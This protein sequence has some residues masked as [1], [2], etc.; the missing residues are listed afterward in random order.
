MNQQTAGFR[1]DRAT[2][3]AYI[4]LTL[5][6]LQISFIGPIMPFLRAEMGLSYMEG[7]LH[8]SAFAL[9]MMATGFLCA[10]LE[11]LIGRKGAMIVAALGLTIGF[12][13]LVVARTPIL[14]ILAAGGMGLIGS[15]IVVY[16]PLVLLGIHGQEGGRAIS[17]SNLMS[18]LGA[19]IA[20]MAVWLFTDTIGWRAVGMVGWVIMLVSM[21]AIRGAH[22]PSN[23]EEVAHTGS[24]LG[25]TYWTYWF[26]LAISV[27]VE[28]CF[29]VWSASF[30]E[31]IGG[32]I[33]D[34]AVLGSSLFSL[35]V[36]SGRILGMFAIRRLGAWRLALVSLCVALCGFLIFWLSGFAWLIL[37]GLG[38]AGLGVANLYATSL[39]LAL[40]AEPN[41]AT[42]AAARTSMA[43]G[44]AIILTPL[45]LGALAD[46]VGLFVG[47]AIVPILVLMGIAS[48]WVGSRG[49][50]LNSPPSGLAPTG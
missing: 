17:E 41:N 27:G 21:A 43:S 50:M 11:R 34:H 40:S 33:R 37:V 31:K 45:I 7:A 25:R 29:G 42:L 5:L 46:S 38:V 13:T 22:L 36:L 10:P 23:N 14:T 35:G 18:Y 12:S 6:M 32:F 48:L 24:P 30:L 49:L 28:F 15:M 16:V 4:L 20:P 1:R 3:T 8:T 44:S 2:W 39:T 26:L 19:L 47:Y 9:G